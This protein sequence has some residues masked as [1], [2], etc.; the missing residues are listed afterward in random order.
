MIDK[1]A[2]AV[3]VLA[4]A[5]AACGLFLPV[6]KD[7]SALGGSIYNRVIEFNEGITVDGTTVI[8]GA[9][10]LTPTSLSVTGT[11]TLGDAATDFITF[12]GK[13]TGQLYFN[14]TAKTA[15]T[16]KV[17]NHATTT[18]EIGSYE[19][20][21]DTSKTSGAF[22]G[23]WQDANLNETGTGSATAILGVA[24]NV[25]GATNTGGTLI[26][27]YGQA[28]SD[29]TMAGSA[30]M[31]GLYGL[32][33][34]STATTASHVASAWLDSHQA[35][36]VTG[37]HQLLYMT[38]NGAAT[39]D[40]AQYLYCGDKITSYAS[41]DTCSGMVAGPS[42]AASGTPVKVKITVD[43]TPYYINAYPTSNN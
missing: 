1:K 18:T 11:T 32:I 42:T 25:A 35:E 22:T 26:G 15:Q 7:G 12:T 29:G 37:S 27:T 33:E 41:F 23:L 14:D 19:G 5:V 38:N 36:A 6:G 3:S 16:L 17:H 43:G 40:E 9:G 20:K 4:L 13:G 39:M 28:R 31:T 2:I 34:A 30:F 21:S 24:T 10:A 8:S